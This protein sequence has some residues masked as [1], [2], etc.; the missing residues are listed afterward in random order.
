MENAVT[1]SDITGASLTIAE[2][3]LRMAEGNL[4]IAVQ[5]FFE[6]PDLQQ[7]FGAASSNNTRTQS[8]PS[9]GREDSDGVIHLDDSDE[10]EEDFGID[11]DD[12]EDAHAEAA[13]IA[14][15]A[16]A[17]EDAAMAKRLQ[18]ELYA[19][20]GNR[21]GDD[22]RAPIAS[23]TETLVGG[24]NNYDQDSAEM[25]FMAEMDRRRRSR[26]GKHTSTSQHIFLHS[27][28]LQLRL[29]ILSANPFGMDPRNPAR[30]PATPRLDRRRL[31]RSVLLSF[32]SRRST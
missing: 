30:L 24:W 29:R 27:N 31:D 18:E 28:N 14:A 6:N 21:N 26:Q 4:E 12:E 22:V 19:E 3:Y 5:L 7:S 9:A 25:N 2:G 15:A 8:R 11:D 20:G 13:R 17:E 32:S 16:Q 1:F 10:E 23:R